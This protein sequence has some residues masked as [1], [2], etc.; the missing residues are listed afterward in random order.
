MPNE[1]ITYPELRRAECHALLSSDRRRYWHWKELLGFCRLPTK[2]DL[3]KAGDFLITKVKYTKTGE[4]VFDDADVFPGWFMIPL[5]A[6][7]SNIKESS[8]FFR[9]CNS[10][11]SSLRIE[12]DSL[13][14][15]FGDATVLKFNRPLKEVAAILSNINERYRKR[16]LAEMGKEFEK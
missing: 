12:D 11:H 7:I 13:V 14:G 16:K 8:S 9:L 6:G 4:I 15:E 10:L 5:E 1:G 3:F 2:A